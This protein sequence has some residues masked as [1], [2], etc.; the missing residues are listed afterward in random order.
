[1]LKDAAWY[2]HVARRLG[3]GHAVGLPADREAEVAPRTFWQSPESLPDAL[4]APT[5]PMAEAIV[6]YVN[7]GR[8]V[9][10]CPDCGGAQLASRTDR[11]FMCNECANIA[12]GG[13]WR[14]VVW[15]SA[16]TERG[17]EEALG[18]R[19]ARN[20]HWSPLESVADLVA[21]NVENGVG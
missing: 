7:D 21:E 12:I 17:I 16:K 6:A 9:V 19:P 15:P 3:V 11:R 4:G 13:L 14:P 20:A 1:M 2:D 8:W 10:D 5:A 18:A